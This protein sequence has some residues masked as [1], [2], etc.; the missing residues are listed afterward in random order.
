MIDVEE[1]AQPIVGGATF[2]LVAL[3]AIRKQA[4]QVVG[5]RQ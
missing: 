3:D 4:E 5:T 1:P 2:G